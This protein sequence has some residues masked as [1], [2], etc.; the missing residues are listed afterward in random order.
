M[1][2]HHWRGGGGVYRVLRCPHHNISQ[3]KEKE[4][5]SYYSV[6]TVFDKTTSGMQ[7][8]KG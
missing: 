4:F 8:A 7:D 2:K 5:S 6:T 3:K 1:E